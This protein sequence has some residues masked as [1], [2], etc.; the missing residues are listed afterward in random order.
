MELHNEIKFLSLKVGDLKGVGD[1]ITK[2]EEMKE[3]KYSVEKFQR[4]K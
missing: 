1:D 4:D 3:V 2:I